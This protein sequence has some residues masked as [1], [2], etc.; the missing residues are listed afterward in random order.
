MIKHVGPYIQIL[1]KPIQ[2]LNYQAFVRNISSFRFFYD[3]QWRIL[4]EMKIFS[5]LGSSS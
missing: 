4:L 1:G 3:Y 2:C 5:S